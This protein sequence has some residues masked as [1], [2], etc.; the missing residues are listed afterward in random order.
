[1]ERRQYPLLSGLN[2]IEDFL[3]LPDSALD[4]LAGELRARMID[5]VCENGGHLASSLGAVELI[6]AMHRV[7]C[8]PEDRLVFDVGHQAYAHKLLTGRNAR[9]D[10]LRTEGGISGFPKR[11]ESG[12]DAF[13]TGHAS[14]SVSAALG[15]ARAMRLRGIDG[16]AVA[17]IGDGALSGGMAFEALNDA[18][19]SNLPLVVVLNDNDMSIAAN[20]GSLRQSLTNMRTSQG[21]VRFKRGLVRLLDTGPVGRWLS[22][23][24]EDFKNRVKNF[25]LPH[26]LFEE[27]GFTYLGPIDG[28]DVRELTRVLRRARALRRPVIVH[29][30]TQKGRGYAPAEQNPERF[31]GV[32]PHRP[33]GAAEAPRKSNSEVFGEALERLA[34][35]DDRIVAVSAAMP[36]GTGLTRFAR[37][38]PDWFFDVGI[39]E[40]HAVTMAAGMA[41]GGLR[42]VVAIYSSFLQR[43][44]DQLL[45]DVCL[46]RLPVVCALDRA[47]LV[48]EDGETHQ[49]IYDV[50][51][52]TAMPGM[53]IYS[54]ATQQELEA[55]LEM[56]VSRGEP[57]A[58][59]YN[60][61]SLMRREACEPL[62]FGRWETWLPV[63]EVTIVATGCM[64]ELALPVAQETGAGLLNARFLHALDE[65]ALDALRGRAARVITLED[66]VVSFGTRM[67][68]AL[69]PL[70]VVALGVPNE[71]VAQGTVAQQRARYGLTAERLRRIILEG[72]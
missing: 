67:Q 45:H 40:Q 69:S 2:G 56:A 55:M 51:Y 27:M 31:H 49:G 19:E 61:G 62:T 10:T 36:S 33:D 48:G 52:L 18:G 9:F 8:K 22:R 58:I 29:A 43:S 5:V 13:N 57:A 53:A 65:T 24:M 38:Y 12:Y 50:A 6:I 39:A 32:P 42:P 14:T 28:H 63:Q 59:R 66:G 11:E 68:A 34:E 17:L 30:V 44:Y 37:R 1:M 26:L 70:P 47:G 4:A 41:A 16:T 23:H 25:L 35:R 7:F 15:M 46:Q 20:V 3:K 54:P 21:Y 64:L 60:R 71:P 72:V